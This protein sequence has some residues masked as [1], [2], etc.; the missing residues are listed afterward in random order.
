MGRRWWG[1]AHHL[2]ITV[3]M[4][5][6][7]GFCSCFACFVLSCT[8][9]GQIHKGYIFYKSKMVRCHYDL[10][11][12]KIYGI[13]VQCGLQHNS[14]HRQ[15]S[16]VHAGAARFLDVASVLARRQANQSVQSR[17]RSSWKWRSLFSPARSSGHRSQAVED[18][19][20]LVPMKQLSLAFPVPKHALPLH[21]QD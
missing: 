6:Y 14:R 18:W 2:S 12:I 11:I 15:A 19:E 3:Q 20:G 1:G 17:K 16:V 8:L 10:K 5:I 4:C 13:R 7:C 21:L 9:A